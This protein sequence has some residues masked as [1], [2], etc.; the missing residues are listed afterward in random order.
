MVTDCPSCN[1]CV[2]SYLVDQKMTMRAIEEPFAGYREKTRLR[3]RELMLKDGYHPGHP[4]VVATGQHLEMG[5]AEK[6][7]EKYWTVHPTQY[8]QGCDLI[9]KVPCRPASPISPAP[10]RNPKKTS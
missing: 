4:L 5:T 2:H 10:A 1:T 6:T 3:L 9:Y 7:A 8:Y